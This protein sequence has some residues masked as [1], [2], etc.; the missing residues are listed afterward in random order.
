MPRYP[1]ADDERVNR[2]R[3]A[4]GWVELPDR[5]DGPTPELPP[6]REWDDETLRWWA[7]LW[8]KPQATMW[9]QS[10]ES[11]VAMAILY[12]DILSGEGQVASLMAELRQHQDRHGLNPK[13]LLQL[14]WRLPTQA[15]VRTGPTHDGPP[16]KSKRPQARRANALKVIGDD[17]TP[18]RSASA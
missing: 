13:A 12:D 5:R 18:R 17:G 8:S 11:A 15:E 7:S 14:R 6:A 9:D 10:G 1:K 16:S 4:F 2:N 3:P